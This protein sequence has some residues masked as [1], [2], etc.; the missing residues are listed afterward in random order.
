MNLPSILKDLFGASG[1]IAES[2]DG[3]PIHHQE[4][5]DQARLVAEVARRTAEPTD[6]LPP[7]NAQAACLGLWRESLFWA[8]G[9]ASST[10]ATDLQ[11][12]WQEAD[13]RL[14]GEAAGGTEFVPAMRQILVERTRL[15]DLEAQPPAVRRAGEFVSS[16]IVALGAVERAKTRRWLGRARRPAIIIGTP[17]AL[18]LVWL[19]WPRPNLVANRPY[20]LSSSQRPCT[21]LFSCGN[22]FFHTQEEDSPWIDYDLGQPTVLH[23]IEVANRSDCCGE[24][25]LPLVVE[26]SLDENNWQEAARVAEPFTVW[27]GSLEGRTARYVR[28][29]VARHS[30]LHLAGVVIR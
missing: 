10:A 1:P 22:A 21:E 29:R 28:L 30:T 6:A 7:G 26:L 14:L 15:D 9:A 25:T 3:P 5:L 20:R 24:R 8:L 16:L 23:R 11:T 27:K 12:L 19:V 13:P 18:V 4:R 17:L 2:H